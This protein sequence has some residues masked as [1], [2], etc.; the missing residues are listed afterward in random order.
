VGSRQEYKETGKQVHDLFS[1]F[2]SLHFLWLQLD[3]KFPWTSIGISIFF[4]IL[5]EGLLLAETGI[6]CGELTQWIF[7]R[8]VWTQ[9]FEIGDDQRER[10]PVAAASLESDLIAAAFF[11][12]GTQ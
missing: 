1:C 7:I 9:I 10:S 6:Q 8:E 2:V 5:V 11:T 3:C 4:Q 12:G